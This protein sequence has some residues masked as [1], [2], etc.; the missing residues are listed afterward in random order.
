MKTIYDTNLYIDFL[1]SADH[2]QLFSSRFHIRFLSP[3]VIMELNAGAT[4]VHQKRALEKLY[5]PYSKGGR[6]LNLEASHFYK[7]GEILRKIKKGN[8][9]IKAGFS[10]DV[11]IA[12]NAAHS[13]C[14][15]FTRNKK[16]FEIIRECLSFKLQI[17]E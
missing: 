14:T 15:L 16:D 5:H 3:I 9:S 2:T 10:H 12:L 11:L 1:R 8:G 13:G 6:I 7:A 17:V 4:N